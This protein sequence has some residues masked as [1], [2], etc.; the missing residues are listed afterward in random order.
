MK[1]APFPLRMQ[2]IRLDDEE[3]IESTVLIGNKDWSLSASYQT[4]RRHRGSAF[5]AQEPDIASGD[6][7]VASASDVDVLGR[8]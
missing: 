1:Y 8:H 7:D 6:T 5:A 2:S 4:G 3:W